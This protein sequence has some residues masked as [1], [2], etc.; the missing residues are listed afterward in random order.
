M[1]ACVRLPDQDCGEMKRRS[2]KCN[3]LRGEQYIPRN[4]PINNRHI[5]SYSEPRL[6]NDDGSDAALL[7]RVRIE[8][9]SRKV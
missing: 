5:L 6:S 1:R 7:I 4:W 8:E 2:R 3:G 9:A